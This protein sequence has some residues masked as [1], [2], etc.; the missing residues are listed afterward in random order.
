MC[1]TKGRKK[2]RGKAG[3]VEGNKKSVLERVR[4]RR[5]VGGIARWPR[6]CSIRLSGIFDAIDW[7]SV[8]N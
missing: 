8:E 1:P 5:C 6:N 2:G 7:T 3:R 4:E